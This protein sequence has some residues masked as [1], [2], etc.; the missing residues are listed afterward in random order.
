ML[1]VSEVKIIVLSI[2]SIAFSRDCKGFEF[3]LARILSEVKGAT[4]SP[5]ANK[6]R[7]LAVIKIENRNFIVPLQIQSFF[8]ENFLA[9][10]LNLFF[11]KLL[12]LA[13]ETKFIKGFQI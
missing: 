7:Q 11:V 1:R 2:D 9:Y 8:M 4:S 3:K 6:I 12:L 5:C 13:A 10:C